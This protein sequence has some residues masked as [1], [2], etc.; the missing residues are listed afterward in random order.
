[1]DGLD[2]K[3]WAAFESA[4]RMLDVGDAGPKALE[5]QMLSCTLPL[6]QCFLLCEVV[7]RNTLILR[8]APTGFA[9][10][11]LHATNVR[12]ETKALLPCT[13]AALVAVLTGI[14]A[15]QVRFWALTL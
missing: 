9:A 12:V 4:S 11:V 13:D 5:V 14:V 10:S 3:S 6:L 8:D 15:S 7:E 2:N 1:M